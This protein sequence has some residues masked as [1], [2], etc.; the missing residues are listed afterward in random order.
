MV[1]CSVCRNSELSSKTNFSV[2]YTLYI[3]LLSILYI[4]PMFSVNTYSYFFSIPSLAAS[5]RV[6]VRVL[7]RTGRKVNLGVSWIRSQLRG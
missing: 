3:E 4:S 1:C 6:V 7:M 5:W 2:T